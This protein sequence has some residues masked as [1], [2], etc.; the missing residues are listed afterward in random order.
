LKPLAV[1]APCLGQRIVTLEPCTVKKVIEGG[2]AYTVAFK[3]ESGA[4]EK[5]VEAGMVGPAPKAAKA[6]K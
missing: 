2:I 4:E 3:A 5:T 1:G 6:G